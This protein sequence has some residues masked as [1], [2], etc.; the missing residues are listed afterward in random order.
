M[1]KRTKWA[2]ITCWNTAFMLRYPQWVCPKARTHCRVSKTEVCVNWFHQHCVNTWVYQIIPADLPPKA[3]LHWGNPRQWES[4]TKPKVELLGPRSQQKPS[5]MHMF[6][7]GAWFS[8]CFYPKLSRIWNYKNSLN[9]KEIPVFKETKCQN[10]DFK[11]QT[12]EKSE[13]SFDR[14]HNV[15]GVTWMCVTVTMLINELKIT[16]KS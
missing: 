15:G 1:C 5:D 2:V 14:G 4:T 12:S 6:E 9:L 16:S 13:F 10:S 7:I 11:K 8:N 3:P